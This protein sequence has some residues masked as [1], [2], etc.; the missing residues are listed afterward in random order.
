MFIR[1]TKTSTSF[2]GKAYFTYRLVSSERVGKK[3][4]QKTLLNL[5]H[6][7]DLPREQW[8]QLCLRLDRILTGQTTLFDADEAIEKTAQHIYSQLMASSAPKAKNSSYTEASGFQEVDVD[9]VEVIKPRSV[10]AEHV[11]LEALK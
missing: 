10:G 9:S 11:C 3:V 6:H 4:R 2:S 7:F 8:P 5:G 1:Q